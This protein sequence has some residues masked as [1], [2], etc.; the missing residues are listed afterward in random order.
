M[1]YHLHSK[2]SHT[3]W[4]NPITPVDQD[5]HEPGEPHPTRKIVHQQVTKVNLVRLNENGP[6]K[7]I[8][9]GDTVD[10]R[11]IGR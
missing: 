5:Y 4:T 3:H 10:T 9:V 1:Q 6:A 7:F 2:A 11:G 8:D